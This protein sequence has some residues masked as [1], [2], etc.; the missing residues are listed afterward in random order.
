MV[1]FVNRAKM[2]ITTIGT[3][4]RTLGSALPGYA[5]F[6]E[7]GV[8]DGATVGYGIEDG[9]NFELGHCV[10]NATTKRLTCSVLQSKIYG[11]SADTGPLS[12]SGSATIF[13]T[14]VAEDLVFHSDF[15]A[16]QPLDSDLTAIAALS[17]ASFGRSL[18]SQSDGPAIQKYIGARE[19]LAADRTYYVRPDGSNSN[20]GLANTSG[21]AFLTVQKAVDVAYGTLDLYGHNVVIQLATGTY[22]RIAIASPQTGS[23]TITLQGDSGT[24]SNVLLTS[25]EDLP[26][27]IF[28]TITQNGVIDCRNNAVITVKDLKITETGMSGIG[29]HAAAGGMIYFSNLVFGACPTFHIRSSSGA[30]I[31]ALGDYTI[32]GGSTYHISGN[33]A[34]NVRAQNITVTL[35]GTPAFT[36]FAHADFLGL[37]TYNYNSF[38]G[39]ATGKHYEVSENSLIVTFGA[40]DYLP[41]DSAGSAATGGL[42]L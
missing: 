35:T 8:P 15:S 26:E 4:T 39:S 31:R 40:A 20:D 21:G 6:D 25:S 7:A 5:S 32:S 33:S 29:L 23:G 18:L 16:Y 1:T 13:I 30:Y 17:T 24:P 12:L 27:D 38:S 41:G 9:N 34:G 37:I 11:Q 14:A 10:Y 3:G 22:D 28:P 2:S 42:Y 19:T 36:A